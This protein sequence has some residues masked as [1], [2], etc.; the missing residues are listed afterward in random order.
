MNLIWILL[1]CGFLIHSLSPPSSAGLSQ[2]ISGSQDRCP[3]VL[4][5]TCF[6]CG[7]VPMSLCRKPPICPRGGSAEL[8]KSSGDTYGPKCPSDFAL[9]APVERF[10]MSS[11]SCA[12][13]AG[14][15][16]SCQPPARGPV[17][18]TRKIH[19]NMRYSFSWVQLKV[20]LKAR[21]GAT[22][23]ERLCAQFVTVSQS[24]FTQ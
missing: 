21:S 8:R 7:P 4:G 5:F 16:I 3:K 14:T 10:T 2:L 19:R 18:I 24:P 13:V 15:C 22:H 20:N 11:A 17:A 23:I 1:R 9:V 6:C 12:L